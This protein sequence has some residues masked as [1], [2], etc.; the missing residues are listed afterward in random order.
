VSVDEFRLAVGQTF[1]KERRLARLISR[2]GAAPDH[3]VHPSM[4]E[5]EYLKVFVW[6]VD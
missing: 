4:P 5:T 6:N 3:P 1:R 2:T